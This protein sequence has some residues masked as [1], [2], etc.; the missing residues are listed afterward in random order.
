MRYIYI[1]TYIHAYIHISTHICAYVLRSYRGPKDNGGRHNDIC[2]FNVKRP[3]RA[4]TKIRLTDRDQF[5]PAPRSGHS[6]T[7]VGKKIYVFGGE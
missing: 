4:W 6:M 2:V 3:E 1:Y 7:V 5:K